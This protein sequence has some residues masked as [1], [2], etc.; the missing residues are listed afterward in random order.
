MDVRSKMDQI[1]PQL[2]VYPEALPSEDTE[3]TG[4]SSVLKLTARDT[5]T[6]NGQSEEVDNNGTGALAIDLSE[7]VCS[8]Q[9][10][11]MQSTDEIF[12]DV[13][14]IDIDSPSIIQTVEKTPIL[15]RNS[16]TTSPATEVVGESNSVPVPV[17]GDLVQ[18]DS[19]HSVDVV[20]AEIVMDAVPVVIGD[21]GRSPDEDNED[22]NGSISV[23][24]NES[25]D[26]KLEMEEE[27][28]REIIIEIQKEETKR[29]DVMDDA[30]RERLERERLEQDLMEDY[31][32]SE[33]FSGVGFLQNDFLEQYQKHIESISE[34]L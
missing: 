11:S 9:Q 22:E 28:K 1:P 4:Q 3:V 21:D 10:E 15:A 34:Q 32:Q 31:T 16:E 13:V 7:S 23:D 19:A 2:T 25:K 24:V 14:Q 17:A 8:R 20:T 33:S 27:Q 5:V 6:Y 18:E 29:S 30:E 12:E 26:S